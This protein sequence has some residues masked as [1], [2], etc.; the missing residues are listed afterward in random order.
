MK[1]IA[2][3]VLT[4]FVGTGLCAVF[5]QAAF[6]QAGFLD[7]QEE[8]AQHRAQ[9]LATSGILPGELFA[10]EGESLFYAV[11]GSNNV[12]ME[13][14]DFG[15]GV[16]VIDGA[17]AQMPRY[18]ADTDRVEDVDSRIVS[19]MR[20]VQGI[21]AEE[22]KRSEVVSIASFISTQS[23]GMPLNIDL[24]VPQNQELYEAGEFLW[25]VR[26]GE[27]DMS[28][29]I[30][31][32]DNLNKRIRL[33]KLLEIKPHQWPSY[34]FASDFMWTL[35]DRIRT[36]WNLTSVKPADNYSDPMIALSIYMTARANGNLVETPGFGR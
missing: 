30:C 17:F 16:G 6:A 33:Q 2:R 26:T 18:F 14:C 10:F 7:P 19:C 1:S 25:Y 31:H 34:R 28:C 22:L 24:S 32:E 36:C 35:E 13:A 23:N 27:L 11:R 4:V 12:S 21:A 15:L 8:V 5:T 20:D 29:A 9:I 3:F